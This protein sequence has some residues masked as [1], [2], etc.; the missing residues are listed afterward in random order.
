MYTLEVHTEV[1]ECTTDVQFHK[2]MW[3]SYFRMFLFY[4]IGLGKKL[5]V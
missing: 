3:T 2:C 4:F 5:F 1:K